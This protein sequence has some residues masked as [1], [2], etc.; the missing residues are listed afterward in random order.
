MVKYDGLPSA[1]IIRLPEGI[2]KLSSCHHQSNFYL[3]D[4]MPVQYTL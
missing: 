4:T 3:H 2:I 1:A